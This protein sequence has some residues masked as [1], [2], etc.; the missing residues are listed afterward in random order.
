M[1]A[2]A[3][4]SAYAL[5]AQ[6][7]SDEIEH[8]V[9]ELKDECDIW[10][11]RSIEFRAL[12]HA[13]TGRLQDSLTLCA[14]LR[15]ELEHERA[16]NHRLQNYTDALRD[17]Q[18]TCDRVSVFRDSAAPDALA[19]GQIDL[20]W[21]STPVSHANFGHIER[22]VGDHQLPE[23]R[24]AIESIPPGPL[25]NEARVEALLLK[26][27]ICHASGSDWVLEGL[28]QCSEALALC[29]KLS[30]LEHFL[31]KIQYHRGLCQYMLREISTAREAFLAVA[32]TDTLHGRASEYR[33]SCDEM[34]AAGLVKR[35]LAFDEYRTQGYP[36][37]LNS[38]EVCHVYC[39]GFIYPRIDFAVE[40]SL[41][42][43]S[44]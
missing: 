29:N 12:F 28:A 27:A 6:R 17:A 41:A 42:P 43:P 44:K 36:V 11:Q 38:S 1:P 13:Q 3:V 33:R 15:A 8:M 39:A 4:I 2:P 31:P 37:S 9:R 24:N 21:Q 25:S 22:L 32:P 34:E 10:K 16:V 26:S 35:R 40:G 20:E 19:V 23:A 18:Q 7:Y 30:E 5:A 14:A